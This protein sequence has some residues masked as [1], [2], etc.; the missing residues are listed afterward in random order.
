[1]AKVLFANLR[2]TPEE[3]TTVKEHKPWHFDTRMIEAHTPGAASRVESR[4]STGV[5]IA[6]DS[7]ASDFR[8]T[9]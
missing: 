3:V 8:D 1:M 4:H 9:D 6:L 5:Q 2:Q 7:A